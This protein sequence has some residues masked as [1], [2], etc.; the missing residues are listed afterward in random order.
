MKFAYADPPYLGT[1]KFGAAHHYDKYHNQAG[2]FD[3]IETHIA[4]IAQL[5]ADFPDGWAMSL[6]TNSLRL[7]LPECPAEIR[8]CVWVKGWC[9]WK[10]GVHPKYAWEPVLLAGGR[11]RPGVAVRDWWQG[12][13]AT[14]QEIPGS[15]PIGFC[16]WVLDLLGY[17]D[18]LD[19]LDDLFPGTGV[20]DAVAAQGVIA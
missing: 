8:V 15:K 19:I 12:N 18:T 3:R 1:S 14:R 17:D 7:L 16:R 5:V 10:P 20:M 6:G 9:S 4:L 11:K 2:D 13:V